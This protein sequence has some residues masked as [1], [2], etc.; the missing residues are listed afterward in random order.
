MQTKQW[1]LPAVVIVLVTL[2]LS[3]CASPTPTPT[4][5]TS[6]NSP[7]DAVI[8]YWQAIDR[9]DYSAAFD[10]AHPAQN[11]TRQ[12]WIDQH[13]AAWG[14]N[15]G[16]ITINNFTVTGNTSLPP[17]TFPGNFT[18][19]DSVI[20]QTD[21]TY[22]GK[23]TNGTSQFAAVKEAGDGWKFYGSY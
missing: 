7:Q 1:A 2:A 4:P 3:G 5:A 23:E 14:E 15:G 17:D 21:V 12:Q 20:V 9:G 13:R 6:A 16:S 18:A 11:V 10:L 8:Q 22:Y 19:I